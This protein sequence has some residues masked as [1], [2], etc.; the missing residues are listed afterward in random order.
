VSI[1]VRPAVERLNA[2]LRSTTRPTPQFDPITLFAAESAFH[3][4]LWVRPAAREAL[5]GL[6]SALAL[7]GTGPDRF[8]QVG[9]AWRAILA[10]AIVEG[11]PGTGPRLIGGFSFDP[12]RSSTGLWDGFGEAQ[13]LLP[14]RMYATSG[15]QSTI[16][17]N[18]VASA[19][20][21]SHTSARR[22]ASDQGLSADEWQ[23]LVGRVARGMGDGSLGLR[24]VVL[25]RSHRGRATRTLEAALRTLAADYPTCT[26]F[27]FAR[28][29]ACFL[30]A[31]PEPL[32][33]L[34]DGVASTIALAGSAPRGATPAEDAQIADQLLSSP[35]ERG[36][37][38]IV[39]E[40]LR[41]ALA[42][43]C[44][45]VVADAQPQV[46]QLANVQHLLT[47]IR[48][49]VEPGRGVLDLVERLHPTPAVGG[50]P[51]A[52]ALDLIRQYEG[53]DRGWYAGPLGW[54]DATGAGE[55]V[56]GLRSGLV[57]GNTATLF[58]GCGIVADSDP[59]TELA[60]LGWKLR[61]MLSALGFQA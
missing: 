12:E 49:Q 54:V 28:G 33:A 24:K 44:A 8:E 27:A 43:V 10:E 51:K 34:R 4:A 2:V 18:L 57:R 48:A 36:E 23:A 11:A 47:R 20:H 53:L 16:T 6:G 61:P 3:R 30:G 13:M 40:S 58:A 14:D 60:E 15:G 29:D 56:V 38:A 52:P 19:F 39:V 25:A 22:V 26:V 17:T 32:I 42:K 35:K 7:T 21:G 45:R 46:R 5:V 59:G 9:A 50:F 41:Q 55:F 1:E 37:H 31:T